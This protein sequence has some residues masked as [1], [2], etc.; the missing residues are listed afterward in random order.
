M[1]S[2]SSWKTWGIGSLGLFGVLFASWS[3]LPAPARASDADQDRTGGVQLLL[4]ADLPGGAVGAGVNDSFRQTM[5]VTRDI[6]ARRIE[7]L[8]G[9]EPRIAG[10]GA[11]RILV[12]VPGMRDSEALKRL[13]GRTAHLELKL[14][15]VDSVPCDAPPRPGIQYL[16]S[17]EEPDT[18][19]GVQSRAIIS[20]DRIRD[21]RQ[22]FSESR[23]VSVLVSFD[24]YGGQRF[25]QA[26]QA[27]VGRRFA[28]VVDNLIISAPRINEPI[29]GGTAS[30]AGDF[31]VESANQLA[32]QLRSGRLPVALR[33]VEERSFGTNTRPIGAQ[34]AN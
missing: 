29:L 2:L 33:V 22:D 30:I 9:F 12:Q 3:L 25:A 13:V 11:N 23:E 28:I 16:P 34:V 32:I 1:L 5:A 8:G 26:T 24:T 21:A 17:A 15:E 14:V 19:M 31:T 18:C 10:Q 7:A 4:E 6:I 27:N 20:G